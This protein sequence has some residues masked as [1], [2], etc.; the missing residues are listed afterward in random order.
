MLGATI[1]QNWLDLRAER[2]PSTFDQRQA[3]S[4]QIQYT[5]GMGIGGRT[6]LS[7]WRGQ[8]AEGLDGAEPDLGEQRFAGDTDL[9]GGGAGHGCHRNDSS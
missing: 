2:G 4:A 6:L 5:S 1:A 7:G 3:L 8:A 9:S